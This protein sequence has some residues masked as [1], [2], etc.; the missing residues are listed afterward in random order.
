LNHSTHG[1]AVVFRLTDKGLRYL[2]VEASGTRDRWVFPKGRV[3]SKETAA[4]TALREVAE[5]AGVRARAL[6]RLRRVEQKQQWKAISIAYFLMAYAGRTTPL[7]RRRIRWLG[8]EEALEALDLEKSRR[9]LRSANRMVSLATGKAPHLGVRRAAARLAAWLVRRARAL[10]PRR[11][12]R[13]S[14]RKSGP[15]R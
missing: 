8:F 14:R 7:D 3:K 4:A 9:V 2:L 10:L 13:G 11:R 12:T 5:E 1:G 15:P 6:R